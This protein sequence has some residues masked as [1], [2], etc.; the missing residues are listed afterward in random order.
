MFQSTVMSSSLGST[1]SRSRPLDSKNEDAAHCHMPED[2]NLHTKSEKH[3]LFVLVGHVSLL[4]MNH[5]ARDYY[6]FSVQMPYWTYNQ[7]TQRSCQIEDMTSNLRVSE[8]QLST[9][10]KDVYQ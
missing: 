4:K 2:L 7:V 9:I 8:V 3:F 6:T 10:L 1:E 5:T